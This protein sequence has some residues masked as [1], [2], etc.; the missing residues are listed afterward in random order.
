MAA[1]SPAP[2][3]RVERIGR[4]GEPVVVIDGFAADPAAL[5][6][7]AAA[8]TFAPDGTHYPGIKAAV[9]PGLFRRRRADAVGI[10]LRDVFGFAEPASVIDA[11]F[12]ARD[13]RRRRR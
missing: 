7:A 4:E 10:V 8:P 1:P 5:R 12:S 13:D 9:P 6:A 2:S 11:W 3:V